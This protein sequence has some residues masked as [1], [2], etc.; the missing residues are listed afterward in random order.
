MDFSWT[1]EQENL[2]KKVLLLAQE[3]LN[4]QNISPDRFWS[5]EQ[6]RQAATVG[7][8][9]LS[10]PERFGGGGW[11]ALSVA[12]A[13]E[14]LSYGCEDTGLVFSLA[15]H[16]CACSMPIVEY[17]S[18][19]LQE[20]W[21]PGLCNGE[22]IGANA[23]TEENAGSD[24]FALETRAVR[25]GDTYILNGKKS[26]VTN[27]PLA[28]LFVLYAVTN[29]RHGYLG[30]TGFVVER[31]TPGLN[32]SEPLQKMGLTS[33]PACQ[34][35]LQECRIPASNCLGNEGQGALIFNR[36]MQWERACLFAL[37]IGQ[38]ERQCD[39]TIRHVCNRR[40]FGTPLGKKQAVAH[41][42]ADMKLRLESARLLLYRACWLFDQG[43]QAVLEIAL[44]KLAVSEAA[45]QNGLD[46]IQLHGS[47]GYDQKVSIERMLRDAI[48][49]TLFSGTSEMQRDIVARELGL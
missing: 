43:Q 21:L 24:V 46:A 12:Y 2:Y 1:H 42:L 35:I 3:K 15:A 8:Q 48:P 13:L 4:K 7:I 5:R 36:S 37:Y 47:S 39:Q 27:G 25:E 34:V 33:T 49:G 19:S 23:I 17:G 6:W 9:G 31:E 14:A 11:E 38:M 45:I 32:F 29:P 10:V 41:R 28:D 30:L 18:P 44:S 26:Y 20:R 40:Q 22:V 16:L